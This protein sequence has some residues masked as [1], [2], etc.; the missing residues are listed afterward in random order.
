[1]KILRKYI[2]SLLAHRNAI[3]TKHSV[4]QR[5][6]LVVLVLITFGCSDF[7]EVDPPRNTLVS[8]TVFEDPSTVQ[9]ALANLYYSMREERGMVSGTFG[10]TTAMGIYSDELDYYGFEANYSQLY[11]HNL[12]AGN[13]II[14]AWWS[15][16]YRLIYGAN[17]IIE[18]VES[19]SQLTTME[20]NSAKG[21]ALFVRA[22]IHSLLVSLYGEVPYI[23]TTDYLGNNMVSRMQEEEVYQNIIGDLKDAIVLL[24]GFEP[25]SHERAVPD[26]YTAKAL[27]SRNYLYIGDWEMAATLA[28][29]LIDVFSLEPNLDQV[30]LKDS[31]ETIWQLKPEEGFNTKEA[32]QLII[33]AVPGQRYALTDDLVGSFEMGDL[34]SDHWMGSVSDAD[35]TIT[36]HYAFKYKADLNETTS[37]EY[38]IRFRLAE[39]Y[40]IRAEARVQMGDIGGAQQ[41]LNA[42]RNRA[43]LPDTMADTLNSLLD[44][45]YKERRVELFAEQ[46]HRWFDLKRSGRANDV[47]GEQKTNWKDTDVLLPLP[48][49]ELETNP[50]LLPQNTGY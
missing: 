39:Q 15:Q 38:S 11:N 44:A 10:L 4:A 5:F 22:Y 23:T 48:E 20:K 16:A 40:L 26:Q 27:L 47:L 37:L 21:Q 30:F 18:G 50:N 41:D 19:S 31:P 17:A 32:E 1:M 25:T 29:G 43:G 14:M 6:T 49:A 28:T 46:G 42:V 24:E 2:C 34:R 12:T 35:G 13:D 3:L 8:E 45:I 36:L 33:P 9:S 7:V